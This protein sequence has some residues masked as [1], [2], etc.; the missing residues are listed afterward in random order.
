MG[1]SSRQMVYETYGKFVKGL[2]E[3]KQRIKAYMGLEESSSSEEQ[4]I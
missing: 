1:H 3:D 4:V 2:V